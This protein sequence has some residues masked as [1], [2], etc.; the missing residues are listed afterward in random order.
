MAVLGTAGGKIVQPEA[1][2]DYGSAQSLETGVIFAL[3]SKAY[4]PLGT[5]GELVWRRIYVSGYHRAEVAF[6]VMPVIDGRP[7][8]ECRTFV[9]KPAPPRGR[10]EKFSFI[11][12]LGRV[13]PDYEVASGLIGASAQVYIEAEDPATGWHLE[14][15]SIYHEPVSQARNRMADE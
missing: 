1:V 10:E 15:A 2:E 4:A 11:V 9:R 8:V 5:D 12:P 13:H 3:L 14:T 6:E 7:I